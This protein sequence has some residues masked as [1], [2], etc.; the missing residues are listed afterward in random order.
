MTKMSC[1]VNLC[2]GVRANFDFR[3]RP[4]Q[5]IS[6]ILLF[7]CLYFKI[8]FS[9]S[10]VCLNHRFPVQLHLHDMEDP[11]LGSQGPVAAQ[12]GVKDP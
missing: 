6:L 12:T 9:S 7:L 4:F 2:L 8:P 3:Q 11:D 10:D 1:D 5:G